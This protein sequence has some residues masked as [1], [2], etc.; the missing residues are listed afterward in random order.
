MSAPVLC[1]ACAT[2]CAR[3]GPGKESRRRPASHGVVLLSGLNAVSLWWRER[4][5]PH[6]NTYTTYS[7]MRAEVVT[8]GSSSYSE[9]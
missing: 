7:S 1:A 2:C 6:M 4:M 5:D 9:R 3:E 8:E